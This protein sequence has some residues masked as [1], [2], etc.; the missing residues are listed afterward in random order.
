MQQVYDAFTA[1]YK[2]ADPAAVANLYT[3][4]A[5]YLEPGKEIFSGRDSIEANFRPFL[6]SFKAGEG[7]DISFEIIERQISGRQG[8]DIG[9]YLF[10]G[11]RAGKFILLWQKQPSGEWKIR[12]DGYSY[13]N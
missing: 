7:P 1:A 6:G 4:D 2:Q 12:A 8:Y 13:L 9:Y 3:E 10:N 11:K 5:Y